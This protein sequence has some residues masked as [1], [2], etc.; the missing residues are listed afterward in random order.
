MFPFFLF[1]GNKWYCG[2]LSLLS[3]SPWSRADIPSLVSNLSLLEWDHDAPN[4][5][6]NSANSFGVISSLLLPSTFQSTFFFA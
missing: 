4:R 3:D 2:F 5:F 1:N 6:V